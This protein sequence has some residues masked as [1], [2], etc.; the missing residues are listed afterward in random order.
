MFSRALLSCALALTLTAATA[1]AEEA[2]VTQLAEPAAEA[3]AFPDDTAKFSYAI[4]Q[5]FGASLD[6][7]GIKKEGINPEFLLKGL[8]DLLEGKEG[9]DEIERSQIIRKALMDGKKKQSEAQNSYLA[10]NAKKEGV[11]TTPS[12]LQYRVVKEG[13]G[14]KPKETST[15]KVHYKGTF[16]DGKTFDSS[17]DRGKPAEFPLNGVIKGWTEGLQLMTAGSTYEFVIPSDLAYGPEGRPGIPGG[18]VLVF[19]VELLEIVQ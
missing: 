19:Q 4:G 11:K 7:Q 3:P 10:E 16:T 6:Q 14:E 13:A 1:V 17:Y 5:Q 15:V 8:S 2:P 18:S 9:I 12:G